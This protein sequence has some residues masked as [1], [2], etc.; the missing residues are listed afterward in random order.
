MK[1]FNIV[2]ILILVV[3]CQCFAQEKEE[4]EFNSII[5]I[6]SFSPLI[7]YAPRWNIG[8]IRKI[9]KRYWFG[10]ELG[11]GDNTISINFAEKGGWIAKNYK[12]FEIKPELYYDLITKSKLK[13]IISAEFQYVK[14]NDR[15]NNSWYFDLNDNTYYNYESADYKRDKY[16]VNINYNIIYNI[17]SNLALMPKVGFG[18]RKRVV[19]YSNIINSI[20][21]PFFEEER[22]ILPDFNGFLRDNGNTDGFNL[23]FDLRIVYKL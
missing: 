6:S 18:Y 1:P 10:V 13:H 11:Y 22:F 23:N 7:S 21:N 16:G 17:T 20:E 9:N 8:Y 14:H 3:G 2:I 15:F 19:Q 5:T 4:E 12:A